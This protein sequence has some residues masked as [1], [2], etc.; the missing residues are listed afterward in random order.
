M[1]NKFNQVWSWNSLQRRTDAL[2]N[3]AYINAAERLIQSALRINNS[4]HNILDVGA[5]SGL[6]LRQL[7]KMATNPFRYTGID[8]NNEGLEIL[9]IRAEKLK[10]NNKVTTIQNDITE[11]SS[12]FIS[13]YDMIISN[14]CLYTINNSD[15]RQRALDNIR[16]YL[17]ENGSFHI[18]LPSENYSASNI[19]FQCLKDELFDNQNIV[20]KTIRSTLL[21]PYQWQFVLKPIE[22]KV[23]NGQF[24][25]FSPL[26]IEAEFKKSKLK[27]TSF[28]LD[29]GGCG[30][31]VHGYRDE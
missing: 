13:K 29:Y 14:F 17:K 19:I 22:D 2:M 4:P 31:H 9:K 23:N 24:T 11:I 20:L 5:G 15:K 16:L 25:K 26:Q 27:I 6:I 3:K 8:L 21:V 10:L 18:A 28:N 1:S 30:Y 7:D 12:D